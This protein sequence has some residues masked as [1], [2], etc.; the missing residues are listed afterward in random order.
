[1]THP[2]VHLLPV[3]HFAVVSGIRSTVMVSPCLRPNDP[4]C[5]QPWPQS[6]KAVRLPAGTCQREAATRFLSVKRQAR[7]KKREG[8]GEHIR[9]AFVALCCQNCPILLLV[10]VVHLSPRLICKVNSIIGVYGDEKHYIYICGVWH[11][12]SFLAPTGGP[13]HVPCTQGEQLCPR[14]Y[15]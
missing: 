13:G 9:T 12:V 5:T 14:V 8:E 3:S 7:G 10:T 1:M 6:T 2:S 15:V 11:C 4:Y